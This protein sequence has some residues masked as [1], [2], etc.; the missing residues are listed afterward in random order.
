MLILLHTSLGQ[1]KF[2]KSRKLKDKG[3]PGMVT[4]Y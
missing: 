4:E 2:K 3:K 1:I